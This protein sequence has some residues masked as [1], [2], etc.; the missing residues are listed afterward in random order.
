M[1]KF[2]REILIKSYNKLHEV[3]FKLLLLEVCEDH[4]LIEAQF[5]ADAAKNSNDLRICFIMYNIINFS[6]YKDVGN[7]HS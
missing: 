2:E 6:L 5:Y 7:P 4:F 3:F 1:V